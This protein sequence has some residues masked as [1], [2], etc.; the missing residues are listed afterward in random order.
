V[1]TISGG[2]AVLHQTGSARRLLAVTI[3]VGAFASSALVAKQPPAQPAPPSAAQ[4]QKPAPGQHDLALA[5]V[6]TVA[7]GD[8]DEMIKRRYIRVATTYS[9]TNYFIDRGVQRGTVYEAFTLFEEELNAK[10]KSKNI[11]VHVVFIPVSRDEL[12]T[13]VAE[14]RAD[15]AAAALTVTPEREKLVDFS[16]ST[17]SDVNEI[18]VTGPGA[19]A[20]TTIDD[21]S[22]Q[23]VFV[24]RS[25]SYYDSL[26]ALNGQLKQK[27][28]KEV[29]VKL[30]P[31]VLETEDILE[32]VNSGLVKITVA[33]NNLAEFWSQIL[34][35]LSL[36]PAVAVRSGGRL[37]VGVRKNSPQLMAEVS[38]WIKR[39]GPKTM[40]GNMMTQ[41]YLKNTRFARSAT[42]KA[43]MDRFQ[44]IIA[45]FRKYGEQYKVDY[46]LMAA[47]GFQESGLD[48][49]V[50]SKVGAI[51]VMQVMPATGKELK[52][53]DISQVEANIHAGVKYIR[54]MIDQYFE[55]E[56]MDQLNK[57]LFAFASYNAGPG[58]VR[59]LRQEAA[60]RGL[61]PNRWFNNV[62]QI[63]SERIGRETVTY[64]SNI[65]KYYVAY[66]LAV[67][68]LEQRR[69]LKSQ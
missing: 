29:V 50:K 2:S 53:G 27:G 18:V 12:L 36:R 34:P 58:R 15:V 3:F 49:N 41:R 31:D 60:K 19:P 16:P 66:G 42:S 52:V 40:F 28:K 44:Q 10:L 35:S 47:Q 69:R 57:G 4:A 59:Q 48:Q 37:A 55:K 24:R 56:P 26:V 5:K 32:M 63:A 23:E 6:A 9:K 13:S 43:E 61:D 21:L 14:G 33:D 67:E 39:H 54:F 51:G 1:P 8:L 7:T 68:E 64:V 20:I 25:S 38:A 62:E 11:R 17:R 65:Y 22:G 30:A 45:Y 46:L